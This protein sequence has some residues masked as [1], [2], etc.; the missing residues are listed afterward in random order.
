[1]Q[2]AILL[3]SC[4]LFIP[5]LG[6]A[7]SS[8]IAAMIETAKENQ[9]VFKKIT[10]FGKNSAATNNYASVVASSSV[11]QLNMQQLKTLVQQA[12]KAM[13]LDV[14]LGNKVFTLE[15]VKKS[16]LD[17]NFNVETPQSSEIGY[18][19]GVFYQG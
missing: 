16:N 4:V 7:Q 10:L 14:P 1:M 3:L 5:F 15:L 6:L 13:T 8:P 11:L 9:I 12:P 18:D 19:K 2:K 17:E